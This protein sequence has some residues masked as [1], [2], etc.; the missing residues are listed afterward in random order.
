MQK[1]LKGHLKQIKLLSFIT[2]S[3]LNDPK[4]ESGG[5]NSGKLVGLGYK[6][7]NTKIK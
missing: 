7:P 3:V 2:Y 5:I 1:E 6:K 4:I